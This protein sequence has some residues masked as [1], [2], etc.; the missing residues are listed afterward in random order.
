MKGYEPPGFLPGIDEANAAPLCFTSACPAGSDGRVTLVPR[1]D[2]HHGTT[3]LERLERA[4]TYRYY[5]TH[6]RK[7][8]PI[9]IAIACWFG[10]PEA[11][12]LESQV[13]ERYSTGPC[14]RHDC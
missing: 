11:K 2:M 5:D 8:E 6:G 4:R 12:K 1:Y 3:F 7:R 14:Y 13:W 10:G 9:R